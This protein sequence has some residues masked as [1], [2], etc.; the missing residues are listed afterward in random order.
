MD[1]TSASPSNPENYFDVLIIGAGLSGIGAAHFIQTRCPNRTYAILEMRD[2]IG[3]TWDLFRY[4]GIRSDS[5]MYTLGYSFR[6]WKEAKA[7][8]D[9]AS[10]LNYIRETAREEKIEEKIQFHREVKSASWSSQQARWTLKVRNPQSGEILSY[11]CNFL[12]MCSGYYNYNEGYTPAFRGTEHFKGVIIHPQKWPKD[13]DYQD[14]KVIVIGSGAT[15]VTLVPAMAEKAA[16]VIMLQRSPTYIVSM[17]AKDWLGNI[18][19]RLLPS[20]WSYG[21]NRWRNLLSSLAF[22]K[23][24]RSKPN[25][26]KNLIKKGV[27]KALGKNYDVDTHFSPDYKPWDQRLCLVPDGDLF[28]AINSGKVEMVTDHIESFTPQGLRLKS[29]KELEADIVVTATGLQIKLIG[30]MTLQVDGQDIHL[31]NHYMYRGLML[32]GVPNL[33]AALGYTNASWTLKTDLS[34]AYVCRLLN[35][36]DKHGLKSCTP[37]VDK[38]NISD[39]P[40]IDFN[41]GYVLRALHEAP[42]QGS[43]KPWKLHQNYPLDIINFKYSSLNSKELEFK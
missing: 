37:Q 40:I 33:A 41:S 39:E 36:M 10:I 42:K 28:E 7:I 2:T 15:A 19:R 12:L 9:G 22:Y 8:A 13:L 18:L 23:L 24:S 1:S 31:P 20:K 25:F 11:A 6:P 38:N 5:D 34:C 4:P 14:K 26:T 35:H 27:K 3:G 30:G 21:L 16:S 32:S 17:P 29:G 43:V